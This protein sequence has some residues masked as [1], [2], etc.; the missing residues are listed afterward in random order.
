MDRQSVDYKLVV[1]VARSFAPSILN[2]T[3]VSSPGLRPAISSQLI[4]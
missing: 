1:P 4:S 2:P 3:A